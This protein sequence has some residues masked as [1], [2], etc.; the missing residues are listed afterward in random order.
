MNTA[1]SKLVFSFFFNYEQNHSQPL[2][3]VTNQ[4][5]ALLS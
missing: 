5:T 4:S 2:T 1:K 3:G